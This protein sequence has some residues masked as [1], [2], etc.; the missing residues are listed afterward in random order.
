MVLIAEVVLRL[1]VK[2]LVESPDG[3]VDGERAVAEGHQDGQHP[4]VALVR[5]VATLRKDVN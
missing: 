2:I 4:G 3:I 1:A 5:Q